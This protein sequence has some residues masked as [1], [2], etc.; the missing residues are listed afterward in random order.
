[1]GWVKSFLILE[2]RSFLCGF[3]FAITFY[4]SRQILL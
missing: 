3:D 4:K 1:M 2:F